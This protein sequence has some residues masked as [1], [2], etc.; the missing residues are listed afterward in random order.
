MRGAKGGPSNSNRSP[1][2]ARGKLLSP[3]DVAAIAGGVPKLADAA[4]GFFT[5]LDLLSIDRRSANR[6]ARA[7]TSG[8]VGSGRVRR[9]PQGAVPVVEIPRALDIVEIRLEALTNFEGALSARRRC[10]DNRSD[11]THGWIWGQSQ[12]ARQD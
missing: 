8:L 5:P 9:H 1:L 2:G 4:R 3:E 12:R 7:M 6:A 10:G 11:Y